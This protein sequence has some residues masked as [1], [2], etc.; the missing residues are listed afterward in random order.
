MLRCEECNVRIDKGSFCPNCERKWREVNRWCA[1]CHSIGRVPRNVVVEVSC[2]T[3][4]KQKGEACGWPG[5]KEPH[6]RKTDERWV[7]CRRCNGTGKLSKSEWN[8]QEGG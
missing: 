7:K 4:G 2:P 3:H 6:T 1:I 5:C 8:K